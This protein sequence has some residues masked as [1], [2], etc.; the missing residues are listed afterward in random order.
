MI[1]FRAHPEHG[2]QTTHPSYACSN[3]HDSD[4][5]SDALLDV[6][7]WLDGTPGVSEVSFDGAVQS[8]GTYAGTT[9]SNIYCHGDGR[10]NATVSDGTAGFA[11]DDCHPDESSNADAW[12]GMSGEHKKHLEVGY[13]CNECHA[14]V[15]NSGQSIIGPTLHVDGNPT[16]VPLA[17]SGITWN[18]NTCSGGSCHG[19]GHSHSNDG[20]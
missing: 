18:G 6:G 17:S 12:D 14:T 1:T 16:V 10:G 8:G 4:G 15:V 20:W 11:C 7:H 3:C 5:Y 13:A 9:C 2:E 19:S